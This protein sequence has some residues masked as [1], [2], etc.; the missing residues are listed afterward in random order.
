LCPREQF[1]L[2]LLTEHWRFT[3]ICLEW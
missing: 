1:S 2:T 3:S